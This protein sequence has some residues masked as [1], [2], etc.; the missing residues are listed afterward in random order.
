[1]SREPRFDSVERWLRGSSGEN[2][3][4]RLTMS[5]PGPERGTEVWNPGQRILLIGHPAADSQGNIG[6]HGRGEDTS[7]T[8][9]GDDDVN[10]E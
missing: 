2:D 6:H 8:L 9:S 4:P 7:H 1:M 10:T 5:Y 3:L